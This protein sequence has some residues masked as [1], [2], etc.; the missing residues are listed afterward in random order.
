MLYEVIT[1]TSVD[2]VDAALI[3]SDGEGVAVVRP[4]RTY[5]YAAATRARIRAVFGRDDRD[6]PEVRAVAEEITRLHADAVA[7][8]RAEAG[9]EWANLELVG[10]HG[11]TIL[12]APE[13]DVSVLV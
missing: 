12:H 1:G 2:G 4:R 7:A 11:Q 3:V 9:A 5:P 6:A 13:R 10:F 8:L